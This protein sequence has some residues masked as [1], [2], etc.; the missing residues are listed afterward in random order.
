MQVL[1]VEERGLCAENSDTVH[2]AQPQHQQHT[3]QETRKGASQCGEH[4]AAPGKR[5][6]T[7]CSPEHQVSVQS[8][9]REVTSAK[10]S[11]ITAPY[12]CL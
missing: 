11:V 12:K 4:R 1:R 2:T 3:C 8:L 10:F 7:E 6:R 5:G 9:P